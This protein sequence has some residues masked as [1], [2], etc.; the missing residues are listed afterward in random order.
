[1]T[2]TINCSGRN[3]ETGIVE[4]DE[5]HAQLFDCLDD[6]LSSVDSKFNQSS[7]FEAL[8]KLTDYTRTHLRVEECLMRLFGYP[9]FES[10][11]VQHNFFVNKLDELRGKIL[12][13]DINAEM[14]TFLLDWL[15][16]HIQV[17]DMEYV[18]FFKEKGGPAIVEQVKNT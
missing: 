3:F 10:H 1:M 7:A 13:E 16:T 18:E 4:I 15:V 8:E 17:T 6:L 11:L 9:G 12:K 2:T 14:V 5:E